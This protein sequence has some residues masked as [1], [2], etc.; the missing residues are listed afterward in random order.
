VSSLAKRAVAAL[1]VIAAS[2]VVLAEDQ[3]AWSWR[4]PKEERVSFH[5][6]AN[7]DGAGRGAGHMV[8]PGFSVLTAVAALAVHSAVNETAKDAQ[9]ERIQKAADKVLEP[10]QPVLDAMTQ[11]DLMQRALQ[12][13]VPLHVTELVDADAVPASGG[14]IDS[15]S[16]F[17]MTRDQRALVLDQAV[18][19]YR[20]GNTEPAYQNTVRVVSRPLQGS[21]PVEDWNANGG[22]KIRA[23]SAALM[24][25]AVRVA[26]SE[27]VRRADDGTPEKSYRYPE[28]GT[29]KIERAQL[30]LESCDRRVLKS[31]RGW[32]LSV[33]RRASEGASCEGSTPTAQ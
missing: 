3:Q 33:P 13:L 15:A 21:D 29:E 4:M 25:E 19:L 18:V 20:P 10:F 11:R 16:V 24:A 1:L 26:L 7:F 9:K 5:G 2:E 27:S 14:W 12:T 6:M 22:E 31:L 28:G 17:S 30:V 32:L 23:E 8:Y